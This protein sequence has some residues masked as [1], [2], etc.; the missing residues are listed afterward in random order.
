MSFT[1]STITRHLDG[2]AVL[3]GLTTTGVLTAGVVVGSRNLLHYDP[4]LLIYTFGTLLAVYVITY[5]VAV[6]MQ[7]PPTKRY[8]TRGVQLLFHGNVLRNVW[9]MAVDVV[10][11]MA[12][13][14]FI[15]RRDH[16]RWIAHV[17]FSWGT[18]IACAVTFPLVFGWVH[19][20][21]PTD[22]PEVYNI[23]VMGNHVHS[24][25]LHTVESFVTF[26][27]LN[28]AA[29]LVIIGVSIAL[30]R[31]LYSPGRSQARQQFG[32]DLVPLILLLAMSIT[33]LMLTFSIHAMDG[34]GYAEISLIH[35]LTVII[36]LIYLPFGKLFHLFVR[37]LHIAVGIY[38][39]ADSDQP[40]AACRVCGEGF[41]GQMHVS[42][43]KGVLKEVGLDWKME[44]TVPHYADVCPKCRRRAMGAT[45]KA[46]LSDAKPTEVPWQN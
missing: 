4:A 20:E 42:D 46:I 33:G 30:H 29:V 10:V 5:R 40:P 31:R 9:L 43:L 1:T 11:N 7:R 28:I 21:T 45:H 26:N 25:A 34:Y 24:F 18:I 22:N 6:F 8:A 19:F 37:P 44:G 39:R 17:M 36:V 14:R 13:Q 12:V 41:A 16:L 35:A 3:A 23:M 15:F 27:M 32:R 38:R 2:K